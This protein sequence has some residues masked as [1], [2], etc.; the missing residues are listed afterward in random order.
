LIWLSL[1]WGNELTLW[2]S[3]RDEEQAALE[4]LCDRWTEAHP[5]T[6]VI[7]LSVPNETLASKLE[8]TIP[9][10]NGPDLFIFAHDRIADWSGAQLILPVEPVAGMMESAAGA[11]HWKEQS[12]GW[13][14]SV[15]S[16]AL[17]YNKALL[18]EPPKTTAELLALGNKNL[19][20]GNVWLAYEVQQPYPNAAWMHG[21][22]G[23]VFAADK[24][25]LQQAAN[26]Q[27][28]ALI[29]KFAA[30]LAPQEPTRALVA[31]LFNEGKAAMM[32]NGPWFLGEVSPGLDFGITRLPTISETNKPAAPYLTVESL[33]LARESTEAREFGA[34]LAGTEGAQLRSEKGRQIVAMEGIAGDP[35]LNAFRDQASVAI[36][37]PL[38]P[39]MSK[40]WEPLTR[41]MRRLTRG[42]TTPE[43]AA[44]EAQSTYA[45]LSRPIPE[46]ASPVP[47]LGA[48]GVAIL[49]GLVWVGRGLVGASKQILK[50]SF[51]YAYVA[52][53]FLAMTLL[54][55]APF[56]VGSAVS[57]FEFHEQRWHFVGI[58]HFIDILLARDFPLSSP[59]SFWS[60]LVVTLLWTTANVALHVTIGVGMALLLREPWVRLR[61][62][63][64]A[65]LILPWAIPNYITALVWKNLFHQQYGAINALLVALGI[66]PVSW[67]ASF[68]TAFTANL[69]TN[70]WL[71][72][73]FM[74]VVTLG[75]L[76]SIPRDL[77]EAAEVDGAGWWAR[78][79]HVTLPLLLPALGPAVVLGSVWT[80][81]M[82]N[83]IYLVSGGEPDGSTEI[84][85]SQAYR[86]AFTRGHRYGYA[87]AYALIIF[88][89]LIGYS[90]L[91][92]RLGGRRVV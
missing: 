30:T 80:F 28:F 59:L 16:L 3:Y 33:F 88:A 41:A 27:A 62:M 7:P 51:A 63:F 48:L 61:G 22:G 72:F 10:G 31:Q 37:M 50:W 20:E 81:N 29:Q 34:W 57:L 92:S 75:A 2:H 24:V 54:T 23:G 40:T 87:S 79:R 4:L 15:K 18:P 9:R 42:N 39:E 84:L 77:E 74:M 8:A 73:P 36:P 44:A 35:I 89:V 14:L 65:A 67:F 53:A 11:V 32:I 71:G 82:F 5:G 47:W 58:A 64:R 90:R 70:T 13:P 12:W 85:I 21:Y 26:I 25:D 83:I 91:S 78:F 66:P 45:V 38:D 55:V 43:L 6:Q 19:G 17:F 69:C 49:A 56:I 86:W 68:T 52:P 46:D 1:A 76:Q 60:T